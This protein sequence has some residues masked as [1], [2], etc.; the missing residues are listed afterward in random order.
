MVLRHFSVIMRF[1]LQVSLEKM[2]IKTLKEFFP[3]E[4]DYYMTQ[5]DLSGTKGGLYL[6]RWWVWQLSP[7]S[8]RHS[9][10]TWLE[11]WLWWFPAELSWNCPCQWEISHP[12]TS[13]LWGGL[14]LMTG[15]CREEED[16]GLF[17]S[18]QAN[19]DL[20][21]GLVTVHTNFWCL[22]CFLRTWPRPKGISRAHKAQ[23]EEKLNSPALGTRRITVELDH[24]E[25]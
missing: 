25:S 16:S 15:P 10:S 5:T 22:L 9:F 3:G 12:G 14:P 24:V 21:L 17:A 13:Y 6:T 2:P 8:W 18:S 19:S 11:Y 7:P 4:C 20:L 1:F 23:T